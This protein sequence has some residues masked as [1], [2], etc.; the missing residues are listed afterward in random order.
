MDSSSVNVVGVALRPANKEVLCV[1][2]LISGFFVIALRGND[3]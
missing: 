2:I 1:V 3:S